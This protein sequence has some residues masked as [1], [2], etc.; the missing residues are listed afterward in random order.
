M[1]AYFK[2]PH[3]TSNKPKKPHQGSDLC[4]ISN[5]TSRASSFL[6]DGTNPLHHVRRISSGEISGTVDS[7]DNGIIMDV[8]WSNAHLACSRNACQ[9]EVVTLTT[10][11]FL[12]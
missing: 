5:Y 12:W 8:P 11:S 10:D 7:M 1:K 2:V 6:V 9:S 3:A 4:Q